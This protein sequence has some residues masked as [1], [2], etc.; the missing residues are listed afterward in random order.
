MSFAVDVKA[1]PHLEGELRKGLGALPATDRSCVTVATATKLLGSVAIDA[2]L[3]ATLPNAARWDYLIGQKRTGGAFLHW[4]EVHPASS[5]GNI[6]E[7]EAK[8]T[9]LAAW[10]RTTPLGAYPRQIAWIACGKSAFN[11]RHPALRSLAN[12]GLRYAGGHLTI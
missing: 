3:K 1:T 9:W 5:T 6:S 2:A 12:R 10:M 4:I 8:L 7:I 11:S